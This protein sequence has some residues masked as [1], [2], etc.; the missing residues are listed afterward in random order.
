MLDEQNV[1]K[2]VLECLHLDVNGPTRSIKHGL[3][4]SPAINK[5]TEDSSAPAN[6]TDWR[7][8]AEKAEKISEDVGDLQYVCSVFFGGFI[9]LLLALLGSTLVCRT[10][11]SR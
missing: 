2:L 3:P 7:A 4:L 6:L 5:T 11:I 9:R 8:L 10:H 1:G